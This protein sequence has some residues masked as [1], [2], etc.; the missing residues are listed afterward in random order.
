MTEP[1]SRGR[2]YVWGAG[3]LYLGPG[4]PATVH[5]HH[6]VQIC[7]SLSGTVRLRPGPRARWRAYEGAVIPSNQTHE[8]DLAV[9]L[10]ATLWLEPDTEHVR[11]LVQPRSGPS[12]SPIERSKLTAIVPRLLEGWH[13]RC[14]AQRA[15]TLTGEVVQILATGACAGPM[16]E[17]RVARVLEMHAS[18]PERRVPLATA[19]AAVALSPSRLAHLFTPAVGI[20]PRR[21]LLWLRLR[22][23]VRELAAGVSITT[24]AHGAGFADAAHLSR[25]FRR[26]LGFTPSAALRVSTFV[27]DE[28]VER[29]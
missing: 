10:I 29:C 16:I 1:S 12:I 4:L 23:A 27:Q 21:H 18:A 26:M 14:A 20:P 8:S 9:P 19:A 15:V 5:A 6:A 11:R 24:A 17:P 2:F 22:D 25:T 13:G 3:A 7:I 28:P